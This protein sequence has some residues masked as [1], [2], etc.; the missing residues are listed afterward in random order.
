MTSSQPGLPPRRDAGAV[1]PQLRRSALALFLTS[2]LL[3]LLALNGPLFM[4]QIYDRVLASGSIPTLVVLCVLCAGLYGF[5]ALLDSLRA[6]L[7]LRLGEA[8]EIRHRRTVLDAIARLP[9][10][11]RIPGDGLQPIRDLDTIRSFLGGSGPGAFFDLPWVPFYLILCFLFHFWLGVTATIGFVIL[12]SLA[13]ISDFSV[14]R[15]TNI[16]MEKGQ[17]RSAM[18]E[19][20]RR[21]AESIRS[22]GLQDAFFDRWK[23]S[24][25]SYLAANRTSGD[26]SSAM[27]SAS[28]AARQA[29]Q[30]AVLA[31]GA[32]LV[33]EQEA[34]AG[35]MIAASIMVG[36]AMAPVD[37]VIGQWKAFV[38]ARQG[39][40]RLRALLAS[41]PAT[42]DVLELP[43]PAQDL[44]VEG[45]VMCPPGSQAPNLLDINFK[46]EA[47]TVLGIIGPSGSGKSSLARALTGVWSPARGCVRLDGATLAQWDPGV[48]G[49]HVGYLPQMPDLFE[50]TIAQNIGRM[51]PDADHEE[52]VEAAKAAGVHDFIITLPKGYQ[53]WIGLDGSG[54]SGGQRQRIGLARA[55]FGKPFLLVLD[56]PNSNLDREGEL[57]ILA[58]IEGQ[59]ARGG[60]A[61]I[62]AHKPTMIATVDK[63][64]QL[65]GGS[66]KAF[67]T[68][69]EV[70]ANVVAPQQVAQA[71]KANGS[72]TSGGNGGGFVTPLRAAGTW[73][74]AQAVQSGQAGQAN[75]AV[76]VSEEKADG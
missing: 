20:A 14:R 50:G 39:W 42:E 40:A 46:L 59:R 30:S 23:A 62:I 58:A 52:I 3:N 6:R 64:L 61:V 41:M 12:V 36:R 22:M 65:A 32:W 26:V 17:E 18:A 1:L 76:A 25:E 68:R 51:K 21:N 10:I 5:Q 55:L 24:D 35:V 74:N 44:R 16:S 49:Q 43:A 28:R 53:T 67:G 48:L 69:E 73:G 71:G 27:N 8:F 9:L 33:I 34:S 19:A 47:G 45:L 66:I 63:V 54:L 37:V 11:S 15:S 2:A 60:I 38:G 7:L 56:E 70:L 29:L 31:V 57:A 75:Q 4:L 72:G 13:L